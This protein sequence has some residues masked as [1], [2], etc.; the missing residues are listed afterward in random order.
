MLLSFGIFPPTFG[1]LCQEK[2]G[3]PVKQF[4]FASL[5]EA[6]LLLEKIQGD[7][8]WRLFDFW[9]IAFFG[10]F[11]IKIQKKPNCWLL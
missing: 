1:I 6:H 2:S 5:M 4:A 8:I 7:Q 10:Q 9:A 11:F 3:N